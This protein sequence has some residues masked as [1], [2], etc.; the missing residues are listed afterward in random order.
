MTGKKSLLERLDLNDYEV[1]EHISKLE[2]PNP[3]P[4]VSIISEAVSRYKQRKDQR[5]SRYKETRN[6]AWERRF[7]SFAPLNGKCEFCDSLFDDV[8]V[9]CSTCRKEM[10]HKCD[11]HIHIELPFHRR[12]AYVASEFLSCKLRP[13]WFIDHTGEIQEIGKIIITKLF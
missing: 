2:R 12:T 9:Y 10:C 5:E 8:A 11:I 1:S 4:S 6:V 7:A 13:N 3:S